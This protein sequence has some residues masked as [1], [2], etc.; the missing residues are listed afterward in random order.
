[1]PQKK[2]ARRRAKKKAENFAAYQ[3]KLGH[4][5]LRTHAV[6]HGTGRGEGRRD[7]EGAGNG[8]AVGGAAKLATVAPFNGFVGIMLIS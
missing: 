5:D 8:T 7:G 4:Y 2:G 3:E 6:R 1:M